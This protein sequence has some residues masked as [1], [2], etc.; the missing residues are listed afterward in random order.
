[1]KALKVWSWRIAVPLLAVGLWE[2]AYRLHLAGRILLPSP[3]AVWD[4]GAQL[5]SSGV[6]WPNLWSTFSAAI[7]ALALSAVVG[8][9]LGILFGMLPRTWDVLA[10]YLNALNSMPRIALAPVFVVAF[11]IGQSSKVALAF[12]IAVFIFLM[13]ARIGVLSTD[14]E[15]VRMC[16]VMGASRS[17]LFRTLYIPAAIPAVFT[18]LRLGLVF[19]LLGVVGSE[20]IASRAGVGQLITQYS[21]TLSMSPVYALLIVLAAFTSVLTM[22]VGALESAVLR[23]QRSDRILIGGRSRIGVRTGNPSGVELSS[24]SVGFGGL[25]DVSIDIPGGQLVAIV[26]ASGVGKTTILNAVSGL[27]SITSGD[28]TVFGDAPRAGRADVGYMFARDALLPWRTALRNVELGLEFQGYDA[29]T[30]RERARE[31]L[32]LVQLS[33]AAGKFPSELSQ[34]MRQRVA[35][36]R[37]LAGRP[38]LLLM[39]EPFA[40]LDA[41]TRA[42]IRDTFLDIRHNE[43]VFF[44]THDLTEALVVADRVLTIGGGRVR[45]DAEV[46]FSRPR[47]PRALMGRADFR[48]LYDRLHADL[49][50]H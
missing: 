6:L 39:D 10:P 42:S 46:P 8:I 14:E 38:K 45:I 4:A 48:A 49:T 44:V 28:I 43:T 17:Q 20:I 47:D 24:V 41:I 13:N 26:G 27:I 18:A 9:P 15:H 21:G 31:M 37:T 36:A 25:S 33:A 3:R 32:D 23:W 7:E 30:R 35:L 2:L 22:L 12:T 16:T 34:G 50:V 29:H 5:Q 11:G 19:A 1:M 40:A